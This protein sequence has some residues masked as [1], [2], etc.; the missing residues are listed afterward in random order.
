MTGSSGKFSSR[1]KGVRN[2]S[3]TDMIKN[4]LIEYGSLSQKIL[5]IKAVLNDLIFSAEIYYADVVNTG[6]KL[7][8]IVDLLKSVIIP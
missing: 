4:L 6:G 5:T 1:C 8:T 2:K 7:T 3:T